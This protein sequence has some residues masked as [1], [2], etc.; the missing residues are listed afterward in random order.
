MIKPDYP[1]VYI[2]RKK[3]LL[4]AAFKGVTLYGVFI[5]W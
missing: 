3:T 4:N 1:G 2:L 5:N